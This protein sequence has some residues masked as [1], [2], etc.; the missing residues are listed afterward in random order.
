MEDFDKVLEEEECRLAGAN[1]EVLLYFLA[2]LATER[3]ICHDD[4]SPVL[5]LNVRKIFGQRV[6]V[7]DVRGFDAMQN[8]VHDGD[9]VG[10][11][12]LSLAIERFFLQN[13][14]LGCGS[15]GERSL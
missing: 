9:N 6:G 2:F 3:R 11:G 1:G 15:F 12:L 4:I 5:V 14:V 8:Y 13:A 10:K 7:N